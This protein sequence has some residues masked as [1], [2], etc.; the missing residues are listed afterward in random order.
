MKDQLCQEDGNTAVISP[1]PSIHAF[2]FQV[3]IG[4][5]KGAKLPKA[6]WL[7]GSKSDPF[8]SWARPGDKSGDER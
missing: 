6:G 1:E 2:H 7:K 4:N 8:L 3:S 5:R